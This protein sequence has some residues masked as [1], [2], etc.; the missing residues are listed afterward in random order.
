MK[1]NIN[2]IFIT[3]FLLISIFSSCVTNPV[4]YEDA[5]QEKKPLGVLPTI[6]LGYIPVVGQLVQGEFIEAG[7]LAGAMVGGTA[8]GIGTMSEDS[9]EMSPIGLVGASVMAGSIFYSWIDGLVTS[10]QRNK[11]YEHQTVEY[12]KDRAV[13]LFINGNSDEAKKLISSKLKTQEDRIEV[14]YEI[15][16]IGYAAEVPD[17]VSIGNLRKLGFSHYSNSS[18]SYLDTKLS[19]EGFDYPFKIRPETDIKS[20]AVC[21]ALQNDA[22]ALSLFAEYAETYGNKK[23][24]VSIG[25]IILAKNKNTDSLF[26]FYDYLRSDV[27]LMYLDMD[28]IEK[29]RIDI[30]ERDKYDQAGWFLKNEQWDQVI[31]II[32]ELSRESGADTFQAARLNI[33]K[34]AAGLCI[35]ET[36]P[37]K[38]RNIDLLI[39]DLEK[40]AA[41]KEGSE[42][43]ELNSYIQELKVLS[44]SGYKSKAEIENLNKLLYILSVKNG[45]V[46]FIGMTLN[47]LLDDDDLS[48]LEKWQEIERMS[49]DRSLMISLSAI[50]FPDLEL[51]A[52][53]IGSVIDEMHTY[54]Y[55]FF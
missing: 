44:D 32:E 55:V 50:L 20:F 42:L 12:A 28:E 36:I 22:A 3:L 25:S 43:E 2:S 38:M 53:E 24:V 35:L 41:E 14:A 23:E 34:A 27:P 45:G 30:N 16:P 48:G 7:V 17:I 6:I 21:V 40:E 11:Q 5:A 54:D 31:A 18:L 37:E 49:A 13:E 33:L 26:S 29:R 52:A 10:I 19:P 15:A 4:T 47:N 1:K 9:G 46:S 51:S 8:L 39:Q